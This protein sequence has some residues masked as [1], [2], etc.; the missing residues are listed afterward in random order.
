LASDW[1]SPESV[2]LPWEV[3]VP[4]LILGNGKVMSEDAFLDIGKQKIRLLK[5]D[6]L[7]PI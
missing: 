7:F 4:A 2:R 1:V 3:N 6:S 5:C